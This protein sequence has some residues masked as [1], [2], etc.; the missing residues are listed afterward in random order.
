MNDSSEITGGF[1]CFLWRG[2]GGVP[3]S[4]VSHG[5]LCFAIVWLDSATN[6]VTNNFSRMFSCEKKNSQ[7]SPK[8]SGTMGIQ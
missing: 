1:H 7:E 4:G 3:A 5:S 8:R 6:S 2:G